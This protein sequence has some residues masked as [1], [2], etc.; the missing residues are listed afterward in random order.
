MATRLGLAILHGFERHAHNLVRSAFHTSAVLEKRPGQQLVE[1]DLTIEPSASDGPDY[2]YSK[3]Y[4]RKPEA[5]L[6]SET[7]VV[8]FRVGRCAQRERMRVCL[9]ER[10]RDWARVVLRVDA[11]P[12]GQGRL[13]LHGIGLVDPTGDNE[14]SALLTRDA[15]LQAEQELARQQIEL[16]ARETSVTSAVLQKQPGQQRVE[17]DLTIELSGPDGPD[18]YEYSKLYF[19][20]PEAK[21]FAETDVVCFR[22]R[23]CAQRERMRVCLPERL[24]DWTRVV[25][26]VDALPHGQGRLQLHGLDLVDP[27]WDD[28]ESALLTRNARLQAEQ[29][30]AR[31]QAE[32][33][34]RETSVTSAV[35]EMQP[36]QQLVELDLT[37]DLSWDETRNYEYSK[38]YFRK[39][40]DRQFS[41]ADVICFRIRYGARRE[42]IRVCL[43]ERLRDWTR[44]VLR[45]DALPYCRGRLHLHALSLVD[46]SG[47]DEQSAALTRRA[48]LLQGKEWV[49]QQVELSERQLRTF[50]PHYPESL[51]LELTPNCNLTC[52]HCSSHGTPELHR[53]HN[54]MS[55]FA[56]DMLQRLAAEVF[57]HLT[58]INVVGRGE[59]T[60]VS[61]S[62]W[63]DFIGLVKEHQVLINVVTNAYDLKQKITPELIPQIDTLTISIDGITE[64]TFAENRGGASL[65]HTLKEIEY[66]HDL[67]RH[68][69][70]ARRP[71]LCLSWTLKRNNIAEFPEFIRTM[72]RFE[73]ELI[74]ARHLLV[75]HDKDREQTLLDIP[76]EA[77]RHLAVAYA[78][79]REYQIRSECPP[80]FSL[81]A[82]DTPAAPPSESTPV[83][84]YVRD[85]DPASPERVADRCIWFHRTGVILAGGSVA[86]CGRTC[87]ATGGNL[88]TAASFMEVWNGPE[89]TGVR[90]AFG[91][92]D[93]WPQCTNCWYRESRY[94]AQRVARTLGAD[95]ALDRPSVFTA[96]AWDFRAQ[97]H[98]VAAD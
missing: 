88:S 6:F 27:A 90:A 11:L 25:L 57:P 37:I 15:T 40:E 79:M 4:F 72:A 75:F 87:A 34:A 56:P 82:S 33:A 76:E 22:V 78:L 46:P 9:P 60:M 73:P 77:N 17:L 80:L 94:D 41:E 95:H 42:R 3:L 43:P 93:E 5:R 67:R 38:L 70:L 54:K 26:R 74:F 97:T 62:L 21:S 13:Q 61:K 69:G 7:D 65:A 29:E 59:P 86:T 66:Y 68:A 83:P 35:L 92:A 91:T 16:S 64:K 44:I 84:Q 98:G 96:E 36:G 18:G 10:V 58:V 49:R 45:V 89:M 47:D 50:T 20:K 14:E 63:S 23:G 52:G 85:A 81:A 1:L 32:L 12:Y 55:A 24:R 31:Q 30:L 28:E 39:P 71:K 48:K 8:C 2:E 51:G 19:R 53:M